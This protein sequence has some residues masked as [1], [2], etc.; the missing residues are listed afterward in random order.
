MRNRE[1]SGAHRGGTPVTIT[2]IIISTLIG[3]AV[4]TVIIKAMD[5]A[6]G[7]EEP[8][9]DVER[10]QQPKRAIPASVHR[11][12]V[13]GDKFN[14]AKLDVRLADAWG[15][16][17]VLTFDVDTG[18][19][20]ELCAPE[21]VIARELGLSPVGL[22]TYYMADGWMTRARVYR[23]TAIW[24]GEPRRVKICSGTSKM[25]LGMEM[26]KDSVLTIDL[27]SGSLTVTHK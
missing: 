4:A 17:K 24:H 1:E 20:G 26:L 11:G 27:S 2:G 8:Q 23:T 16:S 18:F 19:T 3:L 6:H 14:T 25:L 22:E 10:T 21:R 5:L 12:S 15:T 7:T 9:G 13:T